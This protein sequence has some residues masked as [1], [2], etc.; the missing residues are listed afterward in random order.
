MV[1][2]ETGFTILNAAKQKFELLKDEL[3]DVVH[4]FRYL[5]PVPVFNIITPF[6]SLATSVTRH[7]A[8]I[9]LRSYTDRRGLRKS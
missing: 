6:T 1:G 7:R 4:A 9:I 3:F 8:Q 2:S 5:I